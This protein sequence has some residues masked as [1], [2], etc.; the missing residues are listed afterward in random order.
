MRLIFIFVILLIVAGVNISMAQNDGVDSA[1]NACI[2]NA[3]VLLD[4][5]LA[6]MQKNYY[7]KD[8]VEWE[9]LFDKARVSVSESSDCESAYKAVQWCFDQL[10][11]DHSFIMS[12]AKAAVYNGN[13]NA[14]KPGAA[15]KPL[16]GRIRYELIDD[17]IAYINVPW[18][19][20]TDR[21][22]CTAFADTLQSLI[23]S[24]DQSGVTKYIIDLRKNVGGNCW[25]ML[26][27]L[28]PLL[29]EGT[30]GYF[31]SKNERIPISYRS[32]MSIQGRHSRCTASNPYVLRA[33]KKIV[34]VLV[35]HQTAS[36][37]EIV[38]LAFKGLKDVYL[39]GEPTAGLTT[40]N[41]TYALSDGSMLVLTVS[42][43]ADRYGNITEGKI[44]P[45]EFVRA[46]PH[47]AKDPIKDAAIMFLQ[48]E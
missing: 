9:P 32:G 4:E 20:T 7:R 33:G 41:A 28:G 27:G 38:A 46:H 34:T 17:R 26:A 1:R 48:M 43:E 47:N 13:I 37:G 6:L 18:I 5:A 31:I 36:A 22:I 21:Q 30:L 16:T 24:S 15:S 29:G 23:R 11:E 3:S 35:N 8:S 25:P 2:Q 40:A 42:K 14:N 12:P 19:S 45:D 39:F 10:K 44:Q